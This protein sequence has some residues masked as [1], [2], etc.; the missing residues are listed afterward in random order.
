MTG[1]AS[2]REIRCSYE[3]WLGVTFWPSNK[4]CETKR[5]DLSLK[6]ETEKHSFSGSAEEKL[7]AE[8]FEIA[9]SPQLDFIPLD[10]ITEFPNLSGIIIRS[11]KLPT[12]KSGLFKSELNKIK[13]LRLDR[14]EIKVI[15]PKAFE[16]LNKLKWISLQENNLQT[17]SNKLFKKNPDLKYISLYDSKIHS[18]HPS[19]FDGLPKLRVIDFRDNACSGDQ[20]GCEYCPIVTQTDLQS[21]LK[22]C[23]DNCKEGTTC[24][25]SNIATASL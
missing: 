9:R 13:Y 4:Y 18:V 1:A 15:E 8:T 20:I 14:N 10:I 3:S 22:E 19:F 12:V 25:N 11:C 16:H 2:G 24:H 7:E 6:F 17:L 5:M 21:K 23:F